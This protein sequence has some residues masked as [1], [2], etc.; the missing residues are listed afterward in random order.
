MWLHF[1]IQ[2]SVIHFVIT[3]WAAL[4]N[5][6]GLIDGITYFLV[7]FLPLYMSTWLH[8]FVFLEALPVY[9]FSSIMDFLFFFVNSFA[10]DQLVISG[11]VV[12]SVS[13]INIDFTF[14]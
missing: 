3:R 11:M 7:Q 5:L 8:I 4:V 10:A 14:L 2:D 1:G 12:V 9:F 6:V 13:A